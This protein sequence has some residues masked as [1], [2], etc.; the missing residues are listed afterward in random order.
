MLGIGLNVPNKSQY[1]RKILELLH[2]RRNNT[3][4]KPREYTQG[5]SLTNERKKRDSDSH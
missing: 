4:R 1:N 2:Q 3:R 5:K